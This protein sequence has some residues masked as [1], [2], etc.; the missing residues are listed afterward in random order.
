MKITDLEAI[1]DRIL[2]NTETVVKGGDRNLIFNEQYFHHQFSHYV[3]EYYENRGIDVWRNSILV[4]AH[5]TLAKYSWKEFGLGR[6][7]TTKSLALNKGQSGK[8]DFVIRDRTPVFVEW[9]GPKLYD[10]RLI[11]QDL[12]KLLM[13]KN[14]RSPKIFAAIITS[15]QRADDNHLQEL[16]ARFYAALK[17]VRYI[18]DIETVQE[19]K[20]RNLY[21]FIATVPDDG[22]RKFIWGKV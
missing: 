16:T 7:K 6:P 19:L 2:A 12:T 21:A 4:S 14:A 13:I 5:P 1:F 20:R 15:S 10:E 3:T 11:A 17:F 22:A 18:L 8:M 9:K